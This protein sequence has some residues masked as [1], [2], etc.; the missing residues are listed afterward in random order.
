M[1]ASDLIFLDFDAVDTTAQPDE[2]ALLREA[3]ASG[4]AEA[5][6]ALG[7]SSLHDDTLALDTVRL[8]VVR[9]A[10]NVGSPEALTV[11]GRCYEKGILVEKDRVKAAEYYVR[12][13]RLESPR[14]GSLLMALLQEREFAETLKWRAEHSDPD[15]QVAWAGLF[16][17][18]LDPFLAGET[19]LTEEAAFRLL[20]KA[21]GEGHVPGL[22]ELGVWYY[23]GRGVRQDKD[24]AREEWDKAE[25]LGSRE[26]EVH[27]A[28]TTIRDSHEL[29][30]VE[31]AIHVL[32]DASHDGSILATVALAYCHENGIGFM[33][34]DGEAAKLYRR[35]AQRGSQEA[36]LALKRMYDAIR[37]PAEEFQI[38][39]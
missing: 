18:G 23:S 22:V 14:A 7:F 24:A 21:A 36:Y 10:A 37:P 8:G 16:A 31:Q 9:G 34:H 32:S 38:R 39:E 29:S 20:K 5:Q 26:A 27:I 3:L 2:W 4:S 30:E 13:L 25:R 28:V 35:A 33:K 11:L 17:M 15:A 1:Q 19:H 6:S 12:A